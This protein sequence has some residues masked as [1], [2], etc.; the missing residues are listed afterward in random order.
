LSGLAERLVSPDKVQAAVAAYAD[1]INREN[2]AQRAQ[3]EIDARAAEKIDQATA[4]IMTAIEDGLY[5]PA[6]KA[7]DGTEAAEG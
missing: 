1:Y 6:M 2:R 5:Q 7:R 3:A 4:G